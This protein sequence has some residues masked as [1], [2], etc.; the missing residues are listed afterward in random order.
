MAVALRTDAARRTDTTRRARSTEAVE[1]PELSLVPAAQ[2][3]TVGRVITAVIMFFGLMFAVV[4][5]RAYM[6][7]EQ[8][9]L[10]ELNRDIVRARA[11]YDEL[12]AERALLQSPS[13]LLEKARSF[14]MVPA[15]GMKVVEIPAEVAAE[16]AASVGKIDEDIAISKESKLDDFGRIKRQVGPGR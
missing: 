14:G 9:R 3:Q 7:Q 4:A 11:H 6:A 16:V 13:V 12:R 15:V 8:M 10:D 5:L 1:R 2:R